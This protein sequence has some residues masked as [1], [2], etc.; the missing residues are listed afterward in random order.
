V[1]ILRLTLQS[2]LTGDELEHI[3]QKVSWC[4][5]GAR[6]PLSQFFLAAGTSP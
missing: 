6:P 5:L 3:A 4:L 2:E 1:D